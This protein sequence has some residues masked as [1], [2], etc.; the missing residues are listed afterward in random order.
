[1]I[2]STV[3][4]LLPQLVF[5]GKRQGDHYWPN[6]TFLGQAYGILV[7]GT[8]IA[9]NLRFRYYGAPLN[10]KTPEANI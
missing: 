3:L 8:Q 9:G 4:S 6:V 5:P 1:M 7:R 10:G 2:R